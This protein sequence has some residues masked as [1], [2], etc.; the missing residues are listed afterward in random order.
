[1]LR[2]AM[3]GLVPEVVLDRTDKI[4]FATPERDW[5]LG[6]ARAW[7]ANELAAAKRRGLIAPA[8]ID[9]EWS[10]LQAGANNSGNVWRIVNLELWYR[11]FIDAR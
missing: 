3:R 6:T 9:R 7:M 5:M 4:G 2:A 8:A 11:R 10:R 1:V